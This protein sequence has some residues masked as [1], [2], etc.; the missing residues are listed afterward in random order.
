[1]CV[2]I[3]VKVSFGHLFFCYFAANLDCYSLFGMGKKRNKTGNHYGLQGVT[4]CIST[5][6][7]LILLGI[8]VFSV[9]SARNLSASIKQNLMVTM[10]L[11]EDVTNSEAQ[12]IC[13][14]LRTKSYINSME[15]LS[16]EQVLRNQTQLMGADPSEFIGGNPYLGFIE[17]HMNADYANNDSLQWIVKELRAYPKVG[18]V[19]YQQDLMNSVNENLRKI[20]LVLLVLAVL[21]TFVSF[22]LINN[23]V[24]LSVYARR[25]SIHTMKLVGASWSFIRGPFV[26]RAMGLGLVAS[27]LAILVLGG[28][29]YGLYRYK[30]DILTVATWPV[31]AVTVA[32]VF[33]C[34]LVLT[35]VCATISV[36]KFL[37]MTAGE[38][39]KI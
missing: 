17:L 24:K 11:Q 25:F 38:L 3:H 29:F 15:Y 27:V 13:K 20:N 1:M 12:Q 22:T 39:Y 14:T 19:T 33:V 26:R 16:K 4:L 37:R 21:L 36:T 31:L 18:E 23:T 9:L 8:V 34:G 5:A 6:L 7:V 35:G 28:C 30:P 32:S 10:V 2:L